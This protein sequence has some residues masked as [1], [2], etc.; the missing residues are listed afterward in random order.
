[1]EYSKTPEINVAVSW[2][3]NKLSIKG[4]PKYDNGDSITQTFYEKYVTPPEPATQEELERFGKTLTRVLER[5]YF[6]P[7]RNENYAHLGV[8]YE[9]QEILEEALDLALIPSKKHELLPVKTR[10]W[11]D[12][13]TVKVREGYGRET[14]YI[15]P[16][17]AA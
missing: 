4:K 5:E 17:P 10:M 1:M 8:D 11:I 12:N 9:P 3:V 14:K 7:G 15:Y 16:K 13:G 6:K 2:W